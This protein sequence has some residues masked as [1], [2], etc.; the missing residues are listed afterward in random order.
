MK[1]LIVVLLVWLAVAGYVPHLDFGFGD[2]VAC[3]LLLDWQL[4]PH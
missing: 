3:E 4:G 2:D 1:Y